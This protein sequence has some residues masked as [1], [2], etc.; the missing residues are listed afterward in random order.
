MSICTVYRIAD[1]V[2][3][4]PVSVVPRSVFLLGSPRLRRLS[5]IIGRCG[6]IIAALSWSLK[7]AYSA[8]LS[9]WDAAASKPESSACR[10]PRAS[11]QM[12]WSSSE[13][14]APYTQ[15]HFG[16]YRHAIVQFRRA[17]KKC[18]FLFAGNVGGRKVMLVQ[19]HATRCPAHDVNALAAVMLIDPPRMPRSLTLN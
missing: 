18:S 4:V 19:R 6:C 8:E 16:N 10:V 15:A 13:H 12:A 7:W 3:V 17:L 5:F 11:L 14:C 1:F 2:C 9:A